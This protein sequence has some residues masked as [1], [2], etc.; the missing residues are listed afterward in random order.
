M[1]LAELN[2]QSAADLTGYPSK[3]V[4]RVRKVAS[5]IAPIFDI[6]VSTSPCDQPIPSRILPAH[7]RSLT[8]SFFDQKWIAS[9]LLPCL[10]NPTRLVV[11][12][13]VGVRRGRVSPIEL[14]QK[15]E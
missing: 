5:E 14:Q 13:L 2:P 9:I 12:L 4:L 1:S 11:A 3:D 6:Q 7:S 10:V 15:G 8:A